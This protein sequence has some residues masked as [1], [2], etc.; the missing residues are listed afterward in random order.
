MSLV[1]ATPGGIFDFACTNMLLSP[2]STLF[3]VRVSI[4]GKNQMNLYTSTIRV[5]V[6]VRCFINR[7][8]MWRVDN[9]Q[10]LT[11]IAF[12]PAPPGVA[13][14]ELLEK[15]RRYGSAE[16]LNLFGV[17]HLECL[18]LYAGIPSDNE[19]VCDTHV[20]SRKLRVGLHNMHIY[21]MYCAQHILQH[22]GTA[23]CD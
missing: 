21:G 11:T 4:N 6:G 1:A 5:R 3:D 7:A 12:H 22:I 16:N 15:T 13:H 17:T 14:H 9:E 8:H 23:K 20:A 19:V 2:E 10:N 18:I